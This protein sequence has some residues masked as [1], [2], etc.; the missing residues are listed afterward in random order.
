MLSQ[1]EKYAVGMSGEYFV[2]AELL[3]RGVKAS[4]TMGNAKSADIVVLNNDASKVVV[5]EVK[6]SHEKEWVVGNNIPQ[7]NGQHWVFVHIPVYDDPPRYF[8]LT[9]MELINILS[10]SDKEYRENY[11]KHHGKEFAGRGVV[12]LKFVEAEKYEKKWHSIIDRV[13]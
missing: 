13:S 2:A 9:A 3:R 5:V 12:K 11:Y 10:N 1:K 7:N 4:I 6:S 8:I